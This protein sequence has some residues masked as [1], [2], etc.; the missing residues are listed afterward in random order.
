MI[1][2]KLQKFG[3]EK[4]WY[5]T[6]SAIFGNY[7]GYLFNI[8][9]GG[10]MSNPQFKHITCQTEPMSDNQITELRQLLDNNK[11]SIKYDLSEVGL[12]F[13][14]VTFYES[15]LPTKAAKLNETLD[16]FVKE[17]SER[18]IKSPFSSESSLNHYNLSGT[19]VLLTQQEFIK[20]ASEI[21]QAETLDK[22]NR[23]SYLNG[24]LGSLLYSLPI[25]ILWILVAYY[26]ER[27][28]S[29]LG[30]IIALVGSLGY[31]KFKGKLGFWTKWLLILSNVLVIFLANVAV[32]VFTLWQLDVPFEQ[33]ADVYESENGLQKMFKTNLFISM[34]LGIIGWFWI[35]SNVETKRNFIEEAKKL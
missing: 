26:L 17:L 25:I 12:D 33:M 34:L 32:L 7:E 18:H 9:Q 28:G 29:G 30:V 14:S 20:Q 23:H 15:F 24:F 31:D 1:Y 35:V 5:R 19:G 10:I 4:D 22:L 21:E 16:F 13:I 27:L 8:S 6:K 3:R 2:N 11:K